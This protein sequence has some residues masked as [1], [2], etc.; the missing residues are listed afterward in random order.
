[1]FVGD[2]GD[3]AGIDLLQAWELDDRVRCIAV[4]VDR[5]GDPAKF[6]RVV[7]RVSAV[8]PVVALWAGEG[9]TTATVDG[10]FGQAGVLPVDTYEQ[11]VDTC[12]VLV[13][14]PVVGGDRVAVISDAPAAT[15]TFR[16]AL[17]RSGLG[18][19]AVH[20]WV[21]G[22]SKRSSPRRARRPTWSSR[23]ARRSDACP[24][25]RCSRPCDGARRVVPSS[26]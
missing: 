6:A 12:R 14:A 9:A 13:D 18:Q 4:A 3:V 25:A 24:P 17:A 5:F 15:R 21:T 7:R 16:A 22:P 26:P 10:L 23:S 11:L 2:R 1:M 19:V 20:R 8:K